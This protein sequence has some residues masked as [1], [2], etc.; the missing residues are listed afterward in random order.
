VVAH[1]DYFDA[2]GKDAGF[3]ASRWRGSVSGACGIHEHMLDESGPRSCEAVIARFDARFGEV[4]PRRE[5][6]ASTTAE[7]TGWD[8]AEGGIRRTHS[9][10]LGAPLT[11]R[12]EI[13]GGT[14]PHHHS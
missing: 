14:R 4:I 13:L 2:G 9:R 7:S 3:D 1:L 8:R 10:L 6:L 11:L 12:E 5:A